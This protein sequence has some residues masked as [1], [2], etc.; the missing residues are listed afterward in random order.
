VTDPIKALWNIRAVTRGV[1]I[2]ATV[3]HPT[4]DDVPM[5]YFM[6]HYRGDAWWHPN[7]A[8]L[9]AWVASAGFAGWEWLSSFR[10]DYRDGTPGPYHGV[11]RAWNTTEGKPAL[12]DAA[13]Q[14]PAH[15]RGLETAG[16]PA[17]FRQQVRT[18]LRRK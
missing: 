3:I 17:S 2:I 14:P 7:R 12:L 5:A 8:G 16:R 9:E 15:L 6:G 1:A 10:L 13:D 18:W 11:I 4:A